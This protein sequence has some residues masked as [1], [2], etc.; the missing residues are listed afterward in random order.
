[1]WLCDL[2]PTTVRLVAGH[3]TPFS[4]SYLIH[5]EREKTKAKCGVYSMCSTSLKFI[6]ISFL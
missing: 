2:V 5:S 6:F 1:M 4:I 3:R